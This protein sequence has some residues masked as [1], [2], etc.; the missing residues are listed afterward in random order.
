MLIERGIEML[1]R[2]MAAVAGVALLAMLAVTVINMFARVVAT[3]FFGVVDVISLLAVLVSGLALAEAQRHKTHVA[4][5]LVT[6]RFSMRV[7]LAIALVTTLLSI[8]IFSVAAW[9]LIGYAQNLADVNA[10]TDSLG[11]SYWPAAMLLA[12]GIATLVL[13]L[14]RD[15]LLVRRQWGDPDPEGIW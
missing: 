4:I 8:A 7:Q 2:A 13:V 5:E 3:P 10:R 12:L 1:S 14:V 15:L 6:T 11:I 9:R